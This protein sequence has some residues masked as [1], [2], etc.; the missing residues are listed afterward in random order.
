MMKNKVFFNKTVFAESLGS[1][2]NFSLFIKY[3]AEN[4]LQ[5]NGFERKIIKYQQC[6]RACWQKC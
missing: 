1:L 6:L 4:L 3:F 2:N 5:K